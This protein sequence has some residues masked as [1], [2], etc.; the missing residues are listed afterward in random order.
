MILDREHVLLMT[1]S[2]LHHPLVFGGP[3]LR[4]IF[5]FFIDCPPLLL[6][7][8]KYLKVVHFICDLMNSSKDKNVS[9]VKNS[10]LMSTLL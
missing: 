10:D 1:F 8:V 6:D 5:V 9:V 3:A 7:Y 4:C 2:L